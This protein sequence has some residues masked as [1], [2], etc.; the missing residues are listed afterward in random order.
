MRSAG[1]QRRERAGECRVGGEGAV[2]YRGHR[3]RVALGC[4]LIEGAMR[5]A[6]DA[7]QISNHPGGPLDAT[8][9]GTPEQPLRLTVDRGSQ[10]HPRF[11]PGLRIG[12][13]ELAECARQGAGTFVDDGV[14]HR[15]L[16]YR[17][18]HRRHHAVPLKQPAPGR[19]CGHDSV[20]VTQA[21]EHSLEKGR[22]ARAQPDRPLREDQTTAHSPCDPCG[23]QRETEAAC[24]AHGRRSLIRTRTSAMSRPTE[25]AGNSARAT[26][27]SSS[28]GPPSGLT[29]IST[30]RSTPA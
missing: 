22:I 27:A 16:R 14:H 6:S 13:A 17:R 19:R 12:V 20:E 21:S 1:R 4:P 24:H 29:W 10:D 26:R 30:S 25:V 11:D 9:A 2:A 7:R 28:S 15:A 8:V 5:G 18:H 23:L 3:H